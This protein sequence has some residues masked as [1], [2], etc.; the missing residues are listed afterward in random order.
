MAKS[1]TDALILGYPD[2]AEFA[3]TPARIREVINLTGPDI[4]GTTTVTR[5]VYTV[6]GTVARGDSGG[7]LI[8]VNGRVLGVVFGSANADPET[9]FVLTAGQVAPQMARAGNTAPVPTGAC[10]S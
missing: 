1:G 3:A 5:E 10:I 4:Y 7:P 9:G 2:A 6:R 8:D